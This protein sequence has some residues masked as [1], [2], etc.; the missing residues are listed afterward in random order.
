MANDVIQIEP[1]LFKSYFS[2]EENAISCI[3]FA[4]SVENICSIK[5]ISKLVS[6]RDWSL[7][8]ISEHELT[9]E[10]ERTGLDRD[11]ISKK[12]QKQ[13]IWNEKQGQKTFLFWGIGLTPICIDRMS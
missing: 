9:N 6:H 2:G 1:L 3:L 13:W 12:P 7:N 5:F 4:F 11:K 10:L 8:I